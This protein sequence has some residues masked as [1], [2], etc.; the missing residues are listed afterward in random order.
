MRLALGAVLLVLAATGCSTELPPLLN[1]NLSA[2]QIVALPSHVGLRD[3][4]YV[5]AFT[6]PD[7]TAYQ[8]LSGTVQLQPV[9]GMSQTAAAVPAKGSL[10]PTEY[11]VVNGVAYSQMLPGWSHPRW[12]AT[13]MVGPSLPAND[14]EFFDLWWRLGPFQVEGQ[15]GSAVD[16]AWRLIS[17]QPNMGPQATVRVWIRQRDG[18]PLQYRLSFVKGTTTLRFDGWNSGARVKAPPATDLLP[19]PA[20]GPVAGQL[21]YSSGTLRVLAVDYAY[22]GMLVPA[23]VPGSH[24]VGAEVYVDAPPGPYMLPDWPHWQLLDAAGTAYPVLTPGNGAYGGKG[25]GGTDLLAFFEVADTANG[26][27]TLHT[28]L[29]DAPPSDTVAVDGLIKLS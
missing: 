28:V 11:R 29:L 19:P 25:G 21:R 1:P 22:R 16:R 8:Q 7:G 13:P 27:F 5:S 12:Q 18:Y 4:H 24:V 3:V 10:T 23:P 15:E 6:G 20:N 17:P 2:A 26:P 9:R 14:P